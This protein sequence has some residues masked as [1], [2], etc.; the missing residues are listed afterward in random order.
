MVQKYRSTEWLFD[1]SKGCAMRR[2]ISI[3][4]AEHF[5]RPS[6]CVILLAFAVPVT[7]NSAFC[8]LLPLSKLLLELLVSY[9]IFIKKATFRLLLKAFSS[10]CKIFTNRIILKSNVIISHTIPSFNILSW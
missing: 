6:F 8:F 4:M 9:F 1:C 10:Y 7:F 3:L 5:F 2:G